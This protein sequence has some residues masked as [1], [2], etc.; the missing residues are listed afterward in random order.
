MKYLMVGLGS[1]GQRHLRNLLTLSGPDVEI[2]AFRTSKKSLVLSDRMQ[3]ESITGLE[4]KYRIQ[5]FNNLQIS[6]S[7]PVPQRQA[8]TLL[9]PG[10]RL[11]GVVFSQDCLRR[12]RLPAD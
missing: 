8:S 4:Q 7:A 5:E 12:C 6:P 1:V 9:H 11:K 10:L 3:V 2:S